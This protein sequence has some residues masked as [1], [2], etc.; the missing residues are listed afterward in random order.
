VPAAVDERVANLPTGLVTF[1]F[2]DIEGS[3][4]LLHADADAYA[5][6][7]DRHRD[8]IRDL[9]NAHHGH[10]MAAENDS[11]FLV[12]AD[13]ADALRAMAAVQLAMAAEPW[14][15]QATVRVRI[16]AH[17]GLGSP[18]GYDYVTLAVHQAARVASVGSGGQIVVTADV[19]AHVEGNDVDTRFLGRYR[20]R[21]FDQPVELWQAGSIADFPALRTPA[22]DRHNLPVRHGSLFDRVDEMRS[23]AEVCL[24]GKFLTLVGP[25]GVGKTRLAIEYASRVVDQWPDGVWFVDLAAVDDASAVLPAIMD[26]LAIPAG[27]DIE[28]VQVLAE[29]LVHRQMLLIVDNAEHVRSATRQLILHAVGGRPINSCLFVT[30]RERLAVA[31]ETVIRVEPLSAGDE[32]RTGPAVELFWEHAQRLGP[33]V[34]LGAG[35]LGA[36]RELCERL[37]GLPLA[38]EMAAARI[39]AFRP[40]EILRAVQSGSEQLVLPDAVAGERHETFS[41]LMQ[42]SE[43]LLTPTERAAFVGLGVLSGSFGYDTATAALDGVLQPT[44]VSPALWTLVDKSLLV[45][46]ASAGATRYRMLHTIRDY[47]RTRL[48]A[49]EAHDVSAHLGRWLDRLVG[50]DAP[51]DQAWRDLMGDEMDNVRSV[52][53]VLASSDASLAHR[54]AYSLGC[55][56]DSTSS[57]RVARDEFDDFAAQFDEPTP[58]LV[59]LVAKRADLCLR[60]GRVERGAALLERAWQLQADV[61]RCPWD[62][63]AV[64]RSRGELLVREERAHEAAVLAVGVLNGAPSRYGQGRMLSLLGLAHAELG[65]WADA[66]DA[67]EEEAAV[68]EEL[69]NEAAWVNAR[70]NVAEVLLREG[71]TSEA[72]SAQLECL[73]LAERY[74]HPVTVAYSAIVAARVVARHDAWFDVATLLAAA[75][76]ALTELGE[77]LY[78]TDREMVDGLL[79]SARQALGAD[80]VSGICREPEEISE[81]MARAERT[82]AASAVRA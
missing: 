47:A 42:W 14:L 31:G 44:D 20:V 63:V 49:D 48:S 23:L 9:V 50:P 61:G 76:A 37:D 30:S 33:A 52:S 78:T 2:T 65:A 69:N 40:A 72:A 32:H 27:D 18:R 21:N 51:F 46:E 24:P 28:P 53:S 39:T 75:D 81:M 22:A 12:F 55:Y 29:A 7:V 79:A 68:W 60:A 70:G 66:R 38:I 56:L 34:P 67:F 26:T 59:G 41:N 35:E 77:Q 58:E 3:T 25:G 16:G 11:T 54:L 82:L 74:G 1:V 36:V 45:P 10:V 15:P 64:E 80:E 62:D 6:A 8:I 5:D 19:L 71:R 4:R 17:C 73:H 13:N 57:G 43:G